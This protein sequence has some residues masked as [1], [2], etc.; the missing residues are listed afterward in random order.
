MHLRRGHANATLARAVTPLAERA[1][2]GGFERVRVRAHHVVD[3]A[4][5]D[6]SAVLEQEPAPADRSDGAE[7]VAD[8]QYCRAF[9]RKM[10]HEFEAPTLEGRVSD[11]EHLVDHEDVGLEVRRDR[12][13]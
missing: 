13:A 11:R 12:E 10:A 7:V 6:E 5:C 4:L 3:G 1:T 2:R 8:E 9:P